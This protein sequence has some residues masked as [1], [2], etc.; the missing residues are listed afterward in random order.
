M[1]TSLKT[2]FKCGSTLPLHGFYKH[3]RMTDGH[4][5]KCKACTKRD[6]RIN[7]AANADYYREFERARAMLPHRVAAR[8]AYQK[9]DA[10][11]AA[12]RRATVKYRKNNPHKCTATNAVSYAVREGRLDKPGMCERCNCNGTVIH[13]H[14]EDYNRPL[15]VLW[16]CP[17]CHT[18]RHKEIND[19]LV[20]R[21]NIG[22]SGGLATEGQRRDGSKL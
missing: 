19:A 12:L 17:Q 20:E 1:A 22:W 2:C 9:T 3:P 15:D 14:H 10:G 13:G 7:R 16:L 8:N 5:G 18:E 21:L 11:R 6:V 4:L